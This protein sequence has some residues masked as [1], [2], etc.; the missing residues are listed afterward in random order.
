MNPFCPTPGF[1]VWDPSVCRSKQ[2]ERMVFPNG[3]LLVCPG[4]EGGFGECL[5]PKAPSCLNPEN[6]QILQ[7]ERIN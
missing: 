3:A 6:L 2:I 1:V 4:N 7:E 5:M